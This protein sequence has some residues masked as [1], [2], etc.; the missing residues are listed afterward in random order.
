MRRP[1]IAIA[2]ALLSAAAFIAACAGAPRS[3]V[4]VHPERVEGPPICTSCHEERMVPCDHTVGWDKRHAT[5]AAQGRM[6]C[7]L[8]H[9]PSFCADCHGVKEEIKPSDKR[10]IRPGSNVPHRGEY[11]IQ[12]RIDGRL[13]PAACFSCHGRDNQW[14]CRECH[15]N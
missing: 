12:H 13:N 9:R 7:E 6:L 4:C 10:E 1:S 5:A 2:A 8:C 15:R 3:T 11:L 14:R